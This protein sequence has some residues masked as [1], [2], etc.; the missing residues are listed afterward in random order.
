MANPTSDPTKDTRQQP[1]HA[2]SGSTKNQQVAFEIEDERALTMERHVA[3]QRQLGAFDITEDWTRVRTASGNALGDKRE[4][5]RH[6]V[7]DQDRAAAM[8]YGFD[9]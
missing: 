7:P 8:S 5:D 9:R 4:T 3:Q 2:D 1:A 6:R